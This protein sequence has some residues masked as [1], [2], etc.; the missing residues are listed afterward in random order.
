MSCDY[1]IGKCN[2]CGKP[3]YLKYC[4]MCREQILK[5]YLQCEEKRQRRIE[6]LRTAASKVSMRGVAAAGEIDQIIVELGELYAN[7]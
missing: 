3:V 7:S 2:G 1:A 4:N 6:E 5:T